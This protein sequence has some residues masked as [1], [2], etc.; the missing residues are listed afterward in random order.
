MSANE[1][2]EDIITLTQ[3]GLTELQA[4]VYLALV[5]L[6]EARAGI[7]SEISKVTRPDIYRVLRELQALNLSEKIIGRPEEFRAVPIEKGITGLF[8]NRINEVQELHGKTEKLIQK[9]TENQPRPI[10]NSEKFKFIETTDKAAVLSEILN[11]NKGKKWHTLDIVST[12]KRTVRWIAV[13]RKEI[14]K[15]LDR[16]VRIRIIVDKPYNPSTSSLRNLDAVSKKPEFHIKFAST[17]PP[18]LLGIQDD[19]EVHLLLD[20]SPYGVGGFGRCLFSDH[21]GFIALARRYFDSMWVMAEE[22]WKLEKADKIETETPR[23]RGKK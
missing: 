2:E 17:E 23:L 9:F 1:K 4:R 13:C 11:R 7:V 3:L 18:A 15:T 21:S 19:K 16:G 12:W 6:G 22:Y 14:D 5:K 20:K 8:Q 10:S